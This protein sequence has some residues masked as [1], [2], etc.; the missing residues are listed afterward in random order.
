MDVPV[1]AFGR[2]VVEREVQVDFGHDGRRGRLDILLKSRGQALVIVEVKV[3]TA[4][5]SDVVKHRGY[6][7]WLDMQTTYP[8]RR[9]VI[10]SNSGLSG[11][12]EGFPHRG[13]DEICIRLRKLAPELIRGGRASLAA[14]ILCFAGAVEEN[15]L[16]LEPV[17]GRSDRHSTPIGLGRTV[18]YLARVL[19]PGRKA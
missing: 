3:T 4:D 15:L 11:E 16:G 18:A 2:F 5:D 8:C 10:V 14:L 1:A 12:Y 6:R 19:E 9:A 7:R 13:W 17:V